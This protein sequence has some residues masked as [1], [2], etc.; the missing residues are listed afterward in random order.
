MFR[1]L[2]SSLIAFAT[3][4]SASELGAVERNPMPQTASAVLGGETARPL[5]AWVEF[6]ATYADECRVD[7]S[8][9][10][11]IRLTPDIWRALND[12][13]ARVNRTVTPVTDMQHWG[14]VDRWTLAEDGLGD[15]EDFQLLKRRKLA[16]LGLPRRAMLMTVVLDEND[17]GHAVLMVRTDRGDLVLDNKRDEVLSWDRTPYVYVKRESQDN[18]AWVS[19]NRLS[20]VT[21]TATRR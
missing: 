4:T 5:S 6:C 14:V 20:G 17:E 21:T 13:N 15:C 11:T 3:L 7:A 12:V 8:E 1:L 18:V 19:L 9:P 16:S 10:E 2:L